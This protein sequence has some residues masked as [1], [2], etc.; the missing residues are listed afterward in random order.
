M[1]TE[2]LFLI[3]SVKQARL[4]FDPAAL[5]ENS[6]VFSLVLTFCFLYSGSKKIP[7][8]HFT[9]KIIT[10]ADSTSPDKQT[11]TTYRLLKLVTFFSVEF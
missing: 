5:Q 2:K 7:Q 10:S 6:V 4:P 3:S 9:A 11:P 1:C 8:S